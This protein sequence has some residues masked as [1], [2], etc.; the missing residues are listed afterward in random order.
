MFK[1]KAQRV[2]FFAAMNKKKKAGEPI[3]PK[4][5]K[6]PDLP[7]SISTAVK[8]LPDMTKVKQPK[9]KFTK[10]KNLFGKLK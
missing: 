1:S 6:V 8:E 3:V 2:A 9:L 7:P 10:L 4:P 5:P